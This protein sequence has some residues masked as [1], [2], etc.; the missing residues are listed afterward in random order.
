VIDAE[1][2]RLPVAERVDWDYAPKGYSQQCTAQDL[3]GT[4]MLYLQKAADRIGSM[5]VARD[6]LRP[7]MLLTGDKHFL[8]PN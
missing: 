6:R 5:W 2:N 8:Q 4:A 3:S 1:M 7:S